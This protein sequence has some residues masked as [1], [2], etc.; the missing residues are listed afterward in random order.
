MDIF[1]KIYVNLFWCF[2]RIYKIYNEEARVEMNVRE[3]TWLSVDATMLDGTTQ[4]I[5]DTVREGLNH[6]DLITPEILEK[7]TRLDN[8]ESWAY[9]TKTLEYN[10]ITAEGVVNGL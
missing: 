2:R 1:Y 8:V 10:K 4:D 7:I 3:S 9:L 5:T 6:N